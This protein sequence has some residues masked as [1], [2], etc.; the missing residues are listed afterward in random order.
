MSKNARMSPV[1]P[2]RPKT[3]LGPPDPDHSKSTILD[4]LRSRESK[5]GYAIR[6][7]LL[8]GSSVFRSRTGREG[9]GKLAIAVP[10]SGVLTWVLK[11]ILERRSVLF[12]A[13][14]VPSMPMFS[15][16]YSY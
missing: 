1:K 4:S 13:F 5:C 14:P 12:W 3:K 15:L 6:G 7:R 11:A 16:T 8:P 9:P 2:K 10:I